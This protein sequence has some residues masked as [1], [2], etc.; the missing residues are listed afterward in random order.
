MVRVTND[1][2]L[3]HWPYITSVT[4]NDIWLLNI[5]DTGNIHTYQVFLQ[6]FLPKLLRISDCLK[7][8]LL[9]ISGFY[10]I[11]SNMMVQ[12]ALLFLFTCLIHRVA[13]DGWLLRIRG[14]IRVKTLYIFTK[15]LRCNLLYDICPTLCHLSCIQLVSSGL[16]YFF[17]YTSNEWK[18]Q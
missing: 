2:Q 8:P 6:T 3:V 18:I 10:C 13:I 1:K 15:G 9:K 16:L 5:S 17:G 7:Y 4:V 11:Y 12:C 14:R